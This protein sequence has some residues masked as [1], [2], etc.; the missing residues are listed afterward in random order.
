[1]D[2]F[3]IIV[4]YTGIIFLLLILIILG[5]SMG[6]SSGSI[7]ISPI[8]QNCPDY[9]KYDG[10]NCVIP[11]NNDGTAGINTG[12]LKIDGGDFKNSDGTSI[13]GYTPVNK[14]SGAYVNFNDT[15]W[16]LYSSGMGQSVT[17]GL[18]TWADINSIEWDG[19]SNYN[20]C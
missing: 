6:H 20:S 11:T 3:Y 19:V 14:Q 15:T 5:I 13:N 18:K 12:S 2:K 9:W 10:K 17:C 8:K 7:P 4:L 16:P 1:M